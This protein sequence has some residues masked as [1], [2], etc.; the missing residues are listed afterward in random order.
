VLLPKAN[1]E[2]LRLLARGILEFDE[3][4]AVGPPISQPPASS[5]SPPLPRTPRSAPPKFVLE[6]RAGSQSSRHRGPGLDKLD[7]P[8]CPVPNSHDAQGA[9]AARQLPLVA[10]FRAVGTFGPSRSSTAPWRDPAVIRP[11]QPMARRRNPRAVS[12]RW[13]SPASPE[14]SD[15][16]SRCPSRLPSLYQ[17]DEHRGVGGRRIGS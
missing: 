17:T 1:A 13:R 3:V 11:A 2:L 12:R 7:A 16:P 4:L 9:F 10:A 6:A 15:G 5:R 8:C 14:Q